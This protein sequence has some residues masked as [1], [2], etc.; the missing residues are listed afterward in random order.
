MDIAYL[1]LVLPLIP[2]PFYYLCHFLFIGSIVSP[3][4]ASHVLYIDESN[5]RLRRPLGWP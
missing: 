2:Y 4:A 3:V 5:P 1:N